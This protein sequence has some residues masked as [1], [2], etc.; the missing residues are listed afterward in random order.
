MC[1]CL[2]VNTKSSVKVFW[3][4]SDDSPRARHHRLTARLCLAWNR[5]RPW[6]RSHLVTP[7]GTRWCM[8]TLWGAKLS[9]HRSAA[10]LLRCRRRRRTGGHGR[11]RHSLL[12]LTFSCR[13]SIADWWVLQTGCVAVLLTVLWCGFTDREKM[14][15]VPNI[16]CSIRSNNA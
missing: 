2:C 13:G 14:S 12:L 16:V 15:S 8:R 3:I 4:W 5:S 11:Q 10:G 1:A 7:Q 6:C 9:S